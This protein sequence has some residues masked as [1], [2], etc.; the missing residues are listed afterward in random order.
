MFTEEVINYLWRIQQVPAPVPAVRQRLADVRARLDE[1][2]LQVRHR[3]QGGLRRPAVRRR[4][5]RRRRGPRG[6]RRQRRVGDQRPRRPAVRR[7]H[8]RS[9]TCSWTPT[10]APLDDIR[11][12]AQRIRRPVNDV[13]VDKRYRTRRSAKRSSRPDIAVRRAVTAPPK[14]STTSARPGAKDKG[15]VDI[16]E[17]YDLRR[18]TYC[19][20]ADGNTEGFLH[21]PA[22]RCRT[23]SGIRS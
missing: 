12:I 5:R 21:Q 15:F 4:R 14:Q 9:T 23:A 18:K 16:I 2:R 8:L 19:V 11:W 13:R 3:T 17:F 1:G 6:E 10:A 22:G 20:F 7:A